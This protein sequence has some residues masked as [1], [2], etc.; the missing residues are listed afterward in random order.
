MATQFVNAFEIKRIENIDFLEEDDYE[1]LD[2]RQ[3][4]FLGDIWE[5]YVV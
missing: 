4:T 2:E 1:Q 5:N 3:A